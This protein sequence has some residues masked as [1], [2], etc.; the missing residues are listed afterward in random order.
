MSS[1]H[2][3]VAVRMIFSNSSGLDGVSSTK[4]RRRSIVMPQSLAPS[5]SRLRSAIVPWPTQATMSWWMTWLVIQRPVLG[6]LIGLV[7]VG[8]APWT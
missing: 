6:C 7:Q 3:L 8:M 4:K 5:L 2:L 1:A